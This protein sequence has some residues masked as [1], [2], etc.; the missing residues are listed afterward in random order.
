MDLTAFFTGAVE[1]SGRE[2]VLCFVADRLHAVKWRNWKL[3]LIWQEYMQDPPIT[4]GLP[5]AFN[6]YEDPRER[7]DVFLPSNTWLQSPVMALVEE[8]W[9]SVQDHP[10][11]PAGTADP[12]TP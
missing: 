5:R 10:L 1:S 9:T 6:L 7:H 11:I 8:F 3:H 2:S 4:L 12:Y